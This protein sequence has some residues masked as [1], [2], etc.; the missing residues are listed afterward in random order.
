MLV[1]DGTALFRAFLQREHAEENLDFVLKV[2]RVSASQND[3]K[4]S[5][6]D[7]WRNLERAIQNDGQGLGRSKS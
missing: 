2:Q 5:W 3:Q 6:K 7:S 1:T 4:N